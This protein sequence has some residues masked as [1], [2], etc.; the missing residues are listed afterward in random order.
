MKTMSLIWSAFTRWLAPPQDDADRARRRN[1]D[2][3]G[4]YE[5]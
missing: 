5:P 2:R 3:A 4:R 1:V